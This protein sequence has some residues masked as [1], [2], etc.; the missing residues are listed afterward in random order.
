MPD[1]VIHYAMGQDVKAALPPE[2]REK[3]QEAPYVIG[4]Y[5]PDPWFMY[6]PW[7]HGSGR[8]RTMHTRKTGAFLL[9]LAEEARKARGTPAGE[10]LFSYLAGFVCHYAM[11]SASHPYIIWE[12]TQ[13]YR[14]SQSHRAFEHTLDMLEMK[15]A[16]KWQG[17]HPVTDSYLPDVRL[18]GEMRSGMDAAYRRVY[19]WEEAWR[20][21]NRCYGLFYKSYR[22]TEN[23]RGGASALARSTGRELLRGFCYSE[24]YLAEVDAENLSHAEWHS[25]YDPEKAYRTDF[26]AMRREATERAVEIIRAA[27][28]WTLSGKGDP[29][30]LRQVIG[31]RSYLSGLDAED[32]RNWSVPSLSPARLP[33]DPA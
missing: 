19:G 4:L 30:E 23:P 16:G 18:P 14:Q 29:E 25:A 31:N 15:R 27:R 2:I 8:G 3:L 7:V 11:D 32:P 24:N 6:K 22:I 10:Q 20:T 1:V 26:P 17:K 12:T 9:A 13:I 5:G 33:E 21:E 28:S